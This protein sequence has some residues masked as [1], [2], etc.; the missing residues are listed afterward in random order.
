M[1]FVSIALGL[2]S[3]VLVSLAVVN[4]APVPVVGDPFGGPPAFQLPLYLLVYAA[5]VVGVVSGG[6]AAFASQRRV[7]RQARHHAKEVERL[8][9]ELEITRAA[10]G[11]GQPQ[12]A[13]PFH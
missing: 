3:L 11:H 5:L 8:K 7:R 2:V 10:G 12:R 13:L 9:D 4:R 6:V 1:G